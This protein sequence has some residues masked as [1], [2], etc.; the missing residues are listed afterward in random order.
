MLAKVVSRSAVLSKAALNKV[1]HLL[2]LV[3]KDKTLPPEF[4]GRDVLKALLSRRHMEPA[5]LAETPLS[6]ELGQGGLAAWVMVDFGATVFNRQTAIRNALQLLLSENPETLDIVP[7]GDDGQ[8][9]AAAEM[10]VY[11]V[12]RLFTNPDNGQAKRCRLPWV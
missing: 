5:Q 10:A 4:P 9:K 3:P 8:R 2:V 1:S 7:I 12:I 11:S 6:A